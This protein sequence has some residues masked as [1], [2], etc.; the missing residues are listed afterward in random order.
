MNR[1][2]NRS[3]DNP[4][5]NP[6]ST[7]AWLDMNTIQ[8]TRYAEQLSMSCTLFDADVYGG[9]ANIP[10]ASAKS[11]TEENIDGRELRG[12]L[13]V[14]GTTLVCSLDPP[15]SMSM[16]AQDPSSSSSDGADASSCDEN[17]S[18]CGDDTFETTGLNE[19]DG[20]I[21]GVAGP[22]SGDDD[23]DENLDEDDISD[24]E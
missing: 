15:R 23:D 6:I 17:E 4:P 10:S 7:T 19:P 11:T 22:S 2:S 24:P 5:S 18:W 12:A 9:P 8:L 20:V 13:L 1:I 21:S 3:S 16:T 14:Q